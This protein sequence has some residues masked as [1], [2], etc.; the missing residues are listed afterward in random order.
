M[1][2]AMLEMLQYRQLVPVPD[3]D[4]T[5]ATLAQIVGLD[6]DAAYTQCP[7]H[8]QH[9]V[10]YKCMPNTGTES[11]ACAIF[12]ITNR[13][14]IGM[15]HL[16][17]MYHCVRASEQRVPPL[18]LVTKSKMSSFAQQSMRFL[19]HVR[20]MGQPML[21][22]SILWADVLHNPLKHYMVPHHRLV[23]RAYV[24]EA[25][26]RGTLR[27]TGELPKIRTSDPVARYL[28]LRPGQIVA[29]T[30]GPHEEAYRVVAP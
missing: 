24:E 25:L 7:Q 15:A 3:T 30:R 9:A 6:T 21:M 19:Q 2:T 20:T 4:G 1:H 27:S 23:T 22:V 13:S 8:G 17:A 14:K 11:D 16:K 29:I 10:W 28:G 18:H 26:G 12:I 5:A